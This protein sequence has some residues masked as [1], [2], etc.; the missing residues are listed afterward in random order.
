M[1]CHTLLSPVA[2]PSR[3]AGRRARTS[4]RVLLAVI[5]VTTVVAAQSADRPSVRKTAKV[6][7]GLYEI[8][9]SPSTGSVYVA[10]AGSR[11]A[12]GGTV[13]VLNGN[14]LDVL[15]TIDVSS[16]PPYGLALNDRTQTLYTTNTRSGSASA[17]N[18]KTGQ[19]T[20][21]TS[22]TDKNAHLREIAVDE[23]ANVIYASSFGDP[24]RVWVIDGQTNTLSRV[25]E[26][27]GR[28]TAGLAIDHAAGRLYV[29][30]INTAEVA[31]ID[32]ATGHVV[33]RFP[34]GGERPTNLALDA[35]TG[36]L[37]VANQGP[38]TVTVL[39]VKTGKLL[40]TLTAGAGTLDVELNPAANLV[41]AANR[42]NGT[43]SVFN[44]TT[45]APLT[46]LET[47]GA[48]NTLAV[49]SKTGFVYVT[50][51]T[52]PGPGRG[53]G[54]GGD[55]TPAAAPPPDDGQGDTVALIHP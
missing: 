23:A 41:Y 5:G 37:F 33:Q 21:I 47:G 32:T 27:V 13:F 11:T 16:A 20:T 43:V 34:A 7:N 36:R 17:I 25:L 54:R 55:G 26:N 22:D 35:K 12:P 44:A 3:S 48:P 1:T 15:K 50:K 14:T 53:R 45:Y 30:N 40:A 49:D 39:D 24:G 42:V 51:K 2:R 31:V 19:T 6:G 46:T 4:V 18:L 28:G 52:R 9:V 10:S 29:T 8:A 38:G